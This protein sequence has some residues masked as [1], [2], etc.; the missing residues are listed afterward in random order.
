MNNYYTFNDKDN[1]IVFKRHDM[2]SP[3]MNYLSN[4]TL[5][6]MMSQAGGNLSWYKS[7]EIWRIGRYN[8]YNLPVDVA[9]MFIYI[10]DNK[11]GKVW[12]PSFIPCETK[13]DKWE[14]A[15]GIGYTRFMAEKDGVKVNLNCFIGK[16]NVLVYKMQI[17]SKKNKSL[18]VFACQE[19]GMME[20]LREVQW[21]CYCKNSHNILLDKEH[22]ALVYEYF[23]D[24]QARPD[25]TPFV[26]F[27]SNKK[28]KS[29]DGDRGSFIGTYR[30]LKNPISLERNSC[31]NVELR[32]GEAMFAIQV[33]VDVKKGQK[34][35]VN[36]YLG[37]IT[38]E[39][40]FDTLISNLRNDEYVDNLFAEHKKY[41][42]DRLSTFK[43]SVPDS[44][45]QRMVNAWNP[46]QAYVNF[47]V[48]REISFYATGTVR[49]IGV[50]DAS[51]D[52]LANVMYDT[53]ASKDK[54]KLIFTQQ[55]NCGKTNHYF[56]PVELKEPIISDRSDNHLWLVFA[57][58][59]VLVEEGKLDFLNEVVP[60][61]DGGEGTIL[62]HCEKSVQFALDNIGADG[63]P[64]MLGSDWNDMLSN[65]C[66]K[67]KGESV[68]V[69]Q[70]LVLACRYLIE[71]YKKLGK[72]STKYQEVIKNQ[73][74]ILNDFCW[75][76]EWYIRAV[77]DEG[78]KIGSKKE[79]CGYIWINSQSWSVISETAPKER[80]NS[81][82]ENVLKTL[83][84]GYGLLKLYP[85]LQRNYP[86]KENELTFAQPGIGE[87]GGVFCHAN[88]W[89]I[90]A[91]LMLGKNNEAYKIYR[92]FIPHN[93]VEKF[94]VELYT[95][96][97]YIYSSNIRGPK[98]MSGGK[99]GVSWLS[100]TA[101]WMMIALSEYMF[102][103]KPTLDGLRLAPC[104]SDEWGTVNVQ[105]KFRGTTY[106]ITI[107]NTAKRGNS[108]KE[109][110][111]DG[112]KIDG[113]I[114]LSDKETCEV[115]IIMG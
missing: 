96:E 56:Y 3:W 86:S 39:T 76:G 87:N 78:L 50:R 88:T 71:I 73:T 107:D 4:G 12:N 6:T 94:G 110:Y 41:W 80:A 45:T 101:S 43:V 42:A 17:E 100:G 16:E 103:V 91:L 34:Q 11:T 66:K 29:F 109:I 38:Q 75:D 105:R 54:I 48:C 30:S 74:E 97:P 106:N 69:S 18:S 72:D 99:A 84:C 108:V 25:E 10:R 63:I 68:F 13:L 52:V 81:A 67:G 8:F 104:I 62:E 2:P 59:Q 23:I 32:G 65:V 64:L 19:M 20:Y 79:R 1:E 61:F 21:Q 55:Y 89:A 31:G 114:V 28:I 93:V 102:G 58:Y 37:T 22:D 95:A 115:K 27:A 113:N 9:G 51:Q 49:G 46:L 92:D 77:S 53:E 57:T 33:E 5:T 111:V 112:E 14:S 24:M 40:N 7:P 26:F 98:A 85:P 70:M 36:F 60:Y 35:D 82:M 44:D 15:H 90:I 83:D 47:L